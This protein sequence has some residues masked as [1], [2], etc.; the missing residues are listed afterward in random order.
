MGKVKKTVPFGG[1][2]TRKEELSEARAVRSG[3]VS[4]AQYAK[5][6][7]REGHGKGA[8]EKGKKLKDGTLSP[9]KYAEMESKEAKVAKKCKTKMKDGGKVP[10]PRPPKPTVEEKTKTVVDAMKARKKALADIDGMAKGGKVS[11]CRGGGAAT[12]GVKF[13]G[14]K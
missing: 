12:R 8:L 14:V 3:K 9:A 6:E 10:P 5:G 7:A 11:T 4:P 13:R 2:D 1:K